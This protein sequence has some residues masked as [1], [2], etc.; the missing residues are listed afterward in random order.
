MTP[1]GGFYA[2]AM[3]VSGK[4]FRGDFPTVSYQN[5]WLESVRWDLTEARK[6]SSYAK[7]CILLIAFA[8]EI[9]SGKIPLPAPSKAVAKL[10]DI[11]T[12]T[13]VGHYRIQRSRTGRSRHAGGSDG[14]HRGFDYSAA[15]GDDAERDVADGRTPS[16]TSAV[17]SDSD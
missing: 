16:L 7:H 5:C 15:F 8:V 11:R 10:Q 3:Y 14:L 13:E 4:V 17:A 12:P 1:V 6:G 2:A 9:G